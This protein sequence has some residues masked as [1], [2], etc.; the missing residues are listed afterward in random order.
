MFKKG[1][2]MQMQEAQIEMLVMTRNNWEYYLCLSENRWFVKIHNIEED[3]YFYPASSSLDGNV[4]YAWW[5][6]Y[7][8]TLFLEE[9]GLAHE[10]YDGDRNMKS[11]IIL[12]QK[13]LNDA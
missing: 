4:T 11:K 6:A 9:F 2:I 10:Y 12:K 5:F 1:T 13:D 3:Y 7:Y 8:L